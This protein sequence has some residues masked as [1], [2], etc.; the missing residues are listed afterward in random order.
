MCPFHKEIC[1]ILHAMKRY[2]ICLLTLLLCMQGI[3]SRTMREVFVEMPDSVLLLLTHGNRLDLVDFAESHM[4]SKV[5]N[6]LGETTRLLTLREKFLE[7]EVSAVSHCQMALLPLPG[8]DTASVL[9]LVH[10]VRTPQAE[11]EVKFY[12]TDWHLLGKA[13][14]LRPPTWRDFLV[15]PQG[16]TEGERN[17]ALQQMDVPMVSARL[18]E[19]GQLRFELSIDGGFPEIREA[20]SPFLRPEY[21][22]NWSEGRFVPQ[23]Q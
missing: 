6:V 4:E 12:D 17:Q 18:S 22:M 2:C 10:T 16:R 19:E 7:L 15:L 9:C 13:R 14:F 5:K 3:R 23:G 20:V 1:V 8:S 21:V 11:S